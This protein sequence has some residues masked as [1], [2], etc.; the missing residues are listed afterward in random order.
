MAGSLEIVGDIVEPL[1][2]DDWEALQW[3]ASSS[4]PTSGSGTWSRWTGG[5]STA[6]RWRRSPRAR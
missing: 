3:V 6:L 1:G 2:E 5:F 4:T